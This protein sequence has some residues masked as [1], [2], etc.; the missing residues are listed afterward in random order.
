MQI[1]TVEPNL[2]QNQREPIKQFRLVWEFYELIV[3]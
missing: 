3:H 1:T 2:N